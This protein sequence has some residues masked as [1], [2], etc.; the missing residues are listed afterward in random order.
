MSLMHIV[1]QPVLTWS[2]G[3]LTFSAGKLRLKKWLQC[4][5]WSGD[6]HLPVRIS[7]QTLLIFMV[8]N[9]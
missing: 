1:L 4:K 2:L 3:K 6:D 7:A 8:E 5:G 9:H